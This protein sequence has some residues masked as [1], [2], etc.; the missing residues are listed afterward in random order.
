ME[1]DKK[2]NMRVKALRQI[3]TVE[4]TGSN[5]VPP[6]RLKK[7]AAGIFPWPLL[8]GKDRGQPGATRGRNAMPSFYG[9]EIINAGS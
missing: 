6:T 8:L 2:L 5:P 3:H 4:V 7:E 9:Q 1:G